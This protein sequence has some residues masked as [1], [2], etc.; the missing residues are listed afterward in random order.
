MQQNETMSFKDRI[1]FFQKKGNEEKKTKEEIKVVN[2]GSSI[3]E[4][5]RKMKAEQENKNKAKVQGK[6][7]YNFNI[8]KRAEDINVNI[9]QNKQETKQ[10][11]KEAPK[12][13]IIPGKHILLKETEKIKIYKYPNDPFSRD[14]SNYSKILLILGNA[15]N[16]FINTS[17]FVFIYSFPRMYSW[18]KLS[19]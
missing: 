13:R 8:S 14:E 3:Q 15:Q 4:R 10:K 9:K 1:K 17:T 19:I 2:G 18:S 16:D 6:S 11:I 5:I 7:E 12:F